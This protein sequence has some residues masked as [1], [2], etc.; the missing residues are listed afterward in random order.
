MAAELKAVAN[1]LYKKKDYAAAAEAYAK[2]IEAAEAEM[3]PELSRDVVIKLLSNRSTALLK[4]ER[5]EEAQVDAQRGLELAPADPKAQ[6]KIVAVLA[7]ATAA[8]VDGRT[9]NHG[10]HHRSQVS[11]CIR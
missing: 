7:A 10:I 11:F 4:L 3:P 8:G 2:A 6:Q 5:F 1:G 9:R